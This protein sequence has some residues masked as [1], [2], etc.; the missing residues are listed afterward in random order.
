MFWYTFTPFSCALEPRARPRSLLHLTLPGTRP[1]TCQGEKFEGKKKKGKKEPKSRKRFGCPT[2][3]ASSL[4]SKRRRKAEKR[5]ET[6]ICA[7]LYTSVVP[8]TVYGELNASFWITLNFLG[9]ETLC[10]SVVCSSV[11]FLV[12]TFR[13]SCVSHSHGS[14]PRCDCR[15]QTSPGSRCM[16]VKFMETVAVFS[17]SLGGFIGG[18]WWPTALCLS[19]S[20]RY[21][22][23]RCSSVVRLPINCKQ[24]MK[25]VTDLRWLEYWAYVVYPVGIRVA[26]R[27]AIVRKMFAHTMLYKRDPARGS[28]C[29][30]AGWGFVA[31]CVV[32]DNIIVKYLKLLFVLMV[33]RL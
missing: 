6:P 18:V 20:E 17:A 3:L 10:T 15:T 2:S 8:Q 23:W 27:S 7:H 26:R 16:C 5:A 14:L 19:L 32:S 24:P 33:V 21:V 13:Y 12:A 25:N 29:L 1:L 9:V 4:S 28:A 22:I 30:I 11:F 31:L